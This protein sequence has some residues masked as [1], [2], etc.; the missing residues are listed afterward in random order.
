MLI[1]LALGLVLLHAFALVTFRVDGNSMLDTLAPGDLLLISKLDVTGSEIRAFLGDPR[2]YVPRRGQLVVFRLPRNPSLILVKRVLGIP[3]DR[4]RIRD[5]AVTVFEEGSPVGSA[6]NVGPSGRIRGA[7][8]LGSFEGVVPPASLFVLGDNR[9]A[10]A[11]VDSRDW[12]YLPCSDLVG[13]VALRLLPI[14]R[15]DRPAEAP[16]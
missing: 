9:T 7:A 15:S 16:R 10:D 3:G 8:T 14:R 6:P 12:G 13:R 1:P 4:V 2:P 11:S 5:G